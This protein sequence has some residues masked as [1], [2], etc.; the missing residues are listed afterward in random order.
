MT[1]SRAEAAG[2]LL[3]GV[4]QTRGRSHTIGAASF[5]TNCQVYDLIGRYFTAGVKFNF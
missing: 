5:G 4:G 1:N 3:G 2:N